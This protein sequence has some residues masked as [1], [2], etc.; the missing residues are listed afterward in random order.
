MAAAQHMQCLRN[1]R[2]YVQRPHHMRF[3][4]TIK[5][6]ADRL[7]SISDGIMGDTRQSAACDLRG[8]KTPALRVVSGQHDNSQ[9]MTFP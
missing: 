6:T 1:L 4:S 5:V 7:L 9:N 8:K 3:A 2:I